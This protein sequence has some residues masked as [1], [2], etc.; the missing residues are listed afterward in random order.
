MENEVPADPRADVGKIVL[1]QRVSGKSA[2]APRR[3]SSLAN[4]RMEDAKRPNPF[5]RGRMLRV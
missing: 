2:V 5:G 3:I 1:H 4:P